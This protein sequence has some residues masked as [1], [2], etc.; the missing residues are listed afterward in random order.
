MAELDALDAALALFKDP[1]SA[2][3]MPGIALPQGIEMVL[4]IAVGDEDAIARA[5]RHRGLARGPLQE[6]AGFFIE[7]ALLC[8]EADSYR[9]LGATRSSTHDEL[10]HNMAL[11][12][13]WLHPDLQSLRSGPLDREVFTTR[14]SRAWEDLKTDERRSAY[15][16][17]HPPAPPPAPG[18]GGTGRREA[19]PNGSAP[20]K[21]AAKA[22]SGAR[23]NG[24][25][26]GG[27]KGASGRNGAAP[28][29]G[30][31]PGAN[32]AA[33]LHQAGGAGSTAR[34]RPMPLSV[35]RIEGA[36][37]WLRLWGLLWRGR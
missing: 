9:V 17:L 33:K 18:R 37:F 13:R 36:S 32:G 20:A 31:L 30:K 35:H 5:G 25:P 1:V 22:S 21:S 27:P 12:M 10:R 24:G 3:R 2:R 26:K 6:A 14:I 4:A 7:Q 15:D 19:R 28:R 29:V 34:P 16:R 8:H 11:L 23:G